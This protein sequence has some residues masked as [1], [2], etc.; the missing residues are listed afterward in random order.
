M[1]L[2]KL[3][4]FTGN[5]LATAPAVVGTANGDD[6]PV[7]GTTGTSS[8]IV[9]IGVGLELVTNPLGAA[10]PPLLAGGG[11]GGARD[12]GIGDDPAMKLLVEVTAAFN[13]LTSLQ[14]AIQGAPDDGTGEPGTFTSFAFGPVIPLAQL[15][16]GAHLMDLDIPRVP[17]GIAL[18]RYLQLNYL[19]VGGSNT[20]GRLRAWAVLDRADQIVSTTGALSGYTPGITIPN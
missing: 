16:V 8:S 2:D 14:I 3:F 18:P 10:L 4:Q 19:I 17:A 11:G 20:S 7:T 5:V 15:V 1:I 13:V 12:L 9:D 6:F